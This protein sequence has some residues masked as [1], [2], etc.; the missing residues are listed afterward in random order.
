VEMVV[1]V[2]VLETSGTIGSKNGEPSSPYNRMWSDTSDTGRIGIYLQAPA[3]LQLAT[4]K[5][6]TIPIWIHFQPNMFEDINLELF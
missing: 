3:A 5:L 1:I 2:D 4:K 6:R